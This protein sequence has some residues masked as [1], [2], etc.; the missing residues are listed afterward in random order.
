MGLAGQLH[1]DSIDVRYVRVARQF[2]SACSGAAGTPNLVGTPIPTLGSQASYRVQGVNGYVFWVF[3]FSRTQWLG[4][5]L[6][7]PVPLAGAPGCDV[8]VSMDVVLPPMPATVPVRLTIPAVPALVGFE[9]Y[10]QAFVT[11]ALSGSIAP[12]VTSRGMTI[13]INDL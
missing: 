12:L 11:D 4:Q 8:N 13:P 2:G 3:G 1:S 5:P 10:T 7:L 6:P 9:L